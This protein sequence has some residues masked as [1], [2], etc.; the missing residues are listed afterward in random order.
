MVFCERRRFGV[1]YKEQ[2]CGEC[3]KPYTSCTPCIH[4]SRECEGVWEVC[5]RDVKGTRVGA[6]GYT[7]GEGSKEV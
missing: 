1:E 6:K 4:S 7:C 5:W 2:V 3:A